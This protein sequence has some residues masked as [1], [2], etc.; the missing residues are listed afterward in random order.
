MA[1]AK[2]YSIKGYSIHKAMDKK[3]R[4]RQKNR[5][6]GYKDWWDRGC[7]KEKRRL[8]K[9]HRNW[10]KGNCSRQTY[11]E[12]GKRVKKFLETRDKKRKQEERELRMLRNETEV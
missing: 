4:G 6:L 5:L 1:K 9:V 2:G 11:V 7:T 8:H 12:E 10:R 3:K